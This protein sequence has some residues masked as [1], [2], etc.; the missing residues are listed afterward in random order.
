MTRS[1]ITPA[2]L[3]ISLLGGAALTTTAVSVV[4]A[5][6]AK[7]MQ[8]DARGGMRG[9]RGHRG[10]QRGEMMRNIF[11]AVDADGDRAV[12]QEEIDAYRAARVGAADASGD[13]ALSLEE[14][15]T[16][17]QEFTRPRMVDAFQALDADGDG[18]IAPAELDTRIARMV[19]RMDR[20][21]DGVLTLQRGER[22]QRGNN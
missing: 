18:Q 21:G 4:H 15:N 20:D 14:F 19:E 10:G 6:E 3:I 2:I 9:E 1:Y 11:D 7:V 16:L 5:Q 8:A 17:F 12:T 13:G 22:G